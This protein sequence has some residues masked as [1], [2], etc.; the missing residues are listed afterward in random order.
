MGK[1]LG[2]N[3]DLKLYGVF[4]NNDRIV[5]TKNV[6]F[7]EFKLTSLPADNSD[8]V[9]VLKEQNEPVGEVV[10]KIPEKNT[11]AKVEDVGENVPLGEE[12]EPAEEESSDKDAKVAK[13]LVPPMSEPVGRILRDQTLQVKPVRYSHLSKEHHCYKKA[14]DGEDSK[15][16][17]S[18]INSELNNIKHHEVWD[19]YFETPDKYLNTTWVFQTKPPTISTPEKAKVQLC[20][21]GFLQTHGED[22]FDTFSPTG[23]FP[24]FLTLLVLALDLK[25]PIRKF[26]V[27]ELLLRGDRAWK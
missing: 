11:V 27:V 17:V 9:F 6:T 25:L 2:F 24:S 5:N 4:T 16:W 14:V 20:I 15:A 10:E 13:A 3:P 1:L 26:D 19:N 18:A 23:K 8:N 12:S 21:Q 7:L 22:F